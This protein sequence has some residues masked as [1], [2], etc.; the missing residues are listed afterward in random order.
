MQRLWGWCCSVVY[1]IDLSVAGS[2]IGSSS[3]HRLIDHFLSLY[4]VQDIMPPLDVLAG[5]ETGCTVMPRLLTKVSLQR[6]MGCRL[7]QP[8]C[9]LVGLL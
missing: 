4:Y 6:P 5:R 1:W 3:A 8:V 7:R 2:N 9:V